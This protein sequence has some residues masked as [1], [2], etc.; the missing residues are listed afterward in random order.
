M[1][2]IA[3]IGAAVFSG[4]AKDVIGGAFDKGIQLYQAYLNKEISKEQY[5]AEKTKYIQEATATMYQA[6]A[7]AAARVFEA[8][9]ETL[10]ASFTAPSWLTRNTWA[11]VVVSQTLVL[12]WYQIGITFYI[13]ITNIPLTGPGSF[14]RTG[15]ELL[16]WAY[17]VIVAALGVGVIQ[18]FKDK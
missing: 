2:I 3:T 4:V 14:P 11:F 9:Q 17:A 18:R 5:E 12:L 13:Y 1:S 6:Y 15:D 8:A 7:D 16:K 10:R